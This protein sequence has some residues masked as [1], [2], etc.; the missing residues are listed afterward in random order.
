MFGRCAPGLE[1]P[2]FSKK[3]SKLFRFQ[4]DHRQLP[5]KFSR[6][7]SRLQL[8]SPNPRVKTSVSRQQL[9]TIKVEH[10]TADHR[11]NYQG[12]THDSRSPRKSGFISR[13][14]LTDSISLLNETAAH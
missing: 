8:L 12:G 4:A 2:T 9:K 1:V 3:I 13:Q 14:Q 7:T 6:E 5:V 10:M 11:E